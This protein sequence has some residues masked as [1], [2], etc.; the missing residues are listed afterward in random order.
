MEKRQAFISRLDEN[1]IIT[2]LAVSVVAFIIFAFR[3]KNYEPCVPF[4]IRTVAVH[5]Y[6]GEVIR[7]ET[8]ARSFKKLEWNF[9]DTRKYETNSTSSA[10]HTYEKAGEYEVVISADGKCSQNQTVIISQAPHIVDPLKLPTFIG[11]PTAE[12]GKPVTFKDTTKGASRWEWRFGETANVDAVSASPAYTYSS[13]GLKTVSLVVNNDPENVASYKIIVNPAP[14]KTTAPAKPPGGGGGGKSIIFVPTVP[15]H[16]PL[17][18]QLHPPAEPPPAQVAG[19]DITK[20]ELEAKLRQVADKQ[21]TAESFSAYMCG[22]LNIPV[23]LNGTEI[24]F[25]EFCKQ[26]SALKSSKKIKRLQVQPVKNP[27]NHCILSL[28]IDFKKKEG[29]LGL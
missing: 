10:I 16:D 7:F 14:V 9:G 3:Y 18:V 23:S 22:N 27:T 25:T 17:N 6:T 1:V 11:P 5:Y 4:T 13:P 2:M 12:V 20:E 29:F 15:T 21:L 26:L 28:Y 24:T 8:N 19:I